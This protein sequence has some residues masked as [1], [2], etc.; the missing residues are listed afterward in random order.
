MP[1]LE[2]LHPRHQTGENAGLHHQHVDTLRDLLQATGWEVGTLDPLDTALSTRV[3]AADLVVVQMLPHPE[4][5]GIIRARRDRGRP[6]VLEITDNF[7]APP[8]ADNPL[9]SPLVRQR[10]VFH[11]WLADALQVYTPALADLMR[12]V[13]RRTIVFDPYVPLADEPPRRGEDPLTVG[14]GGTRTHAPD[15][16]AIA[17][18]LAR[19]ASRHA[20]VEFSF[21]GDAGLLDGL[22]PGRRRPFGS[23]DAY[24]EFVDELDIGL[25]PLLPTP[26]NVGR[27]DTRF[28]TYAARG[29]AAVIQDATA[30]HAHARRSAPFTDGEELE[31]LLEELYRARGRVRALAAA[32]HRWAR[33]TRSASALARQRDEAYRALVTTDCPLAP[34][35]GD[36]AAAVAL[37]RAGREEPRAAL[38]ACEELLATHPGYE[39]AWLFAARCLERLGRKQEA[40]RR[41][42]TRR[43]SPAFSDLALELIARASG[44]R[45]LADAMT[46][47]F[48]RARLRHEDVLAHQP[49]DHFGLQRAIRAA[50]TDRPRLGELYAR[51]SLVAPDTVPREW[52]PIHLRPFVP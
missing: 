8:R 12:G 35:G 40:A 42:Q 5:E 29:V 39:Q 41:L 28:G 24:L 43:F 38:A 48:L 47:P 36:P 4:V 19:F 11:A 14:W 6:T 46:S 27:T 45:R 34:T 3:L 30:H 26:F 1:G 37:E 44:E 21:M 52:R 2:I 16:D 25:A 10:L 32:A 23:P 7:L 20:D 15:L 51:A 49:Y 33:Q 17:G 9:A 18:P 13:A 31:R 22:P 50:G